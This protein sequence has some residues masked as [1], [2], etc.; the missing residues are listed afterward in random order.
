MRTRRVRGKA[1]LVMA[2]ALALALA[3]GC[4]GGAGAASSGI[5]KPNLNVAVVPALDSAGFFVAL[6][7]GLFKAQGLNVTF[8]PATSSETV[9]AGQVQGE[10]DITGGNYVSY[11]QAQQSGQANLDIFAEGSVMGPGAQAIYTMPGSP[12]QTLAGLE[13]HTIAINAP[14]DILYLLTASVLAE[15]GIPIKTVSFA[16]VAFADMVPDMQSGAI[17]AAVMP[18]PFASDA[19]QTQGAVPLAD[20]NQGATTAFPVEGYVVTK[21]W[22]AKYPHTLA[23]FY[24]ALEEGQQIADTSRA[25]VEAAMENVPAPYGVSK[26]TAAVMAL[27]N[28]PVSTGPV[29]SVDKA[30]LQ[31]VVDVMQQF[32]GFPSFNINSMLMGGG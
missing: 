18:E 27:D 5:E 9:V 4:S 25:A 12:V 29:G 1:L 28:Y 19:E 7:E 2:T 17:S 16:N 30:R 24:K 20:L 21:Q 23:A 22:A 14:K 32:I 3:A 6:N 8:T 11:I 31:R 10:Y 13:N 15:H 26:Q